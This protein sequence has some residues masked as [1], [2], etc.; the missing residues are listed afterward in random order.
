MA[1]ARAMEDDGDVLVLGQDVGGERRGVPR[2][3]GPPRTVRRTPRARHAAGG[4]AHLRRLGRHGGAGPSSRCAK[5]S[6]RGSS[7]PP[8]TSSRTTRRGL[9]TR[10]RG[11]MTCPPWCCAPPAGGGIHAPEH[12]SES[13]E[14]FLA[15]VPGL[16]CVTP[17]TPRA[18]LRAAA[19]PPSAIRIRW[20]SSSRR[21]CTGSRKGRS[22]TT[23]RGLPLGR[24]LRGARRRR[25]HPR[26]VGRRDVGRAGPPR[27]ASKTRARASSSSTSR[28]SRRSTRTPCSIRCAAPDGSSS[29]TRRRT[30]ED[31]GRR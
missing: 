7:T 9:R 29:H 25:R 11:R 12:H 15:H 19:F 30:R 13:I 10:T 24:G 22:R 26:L 6:S 14:A 16:K 2:H 27:R 31:S 4:A 21:A 5:S 20:C 3:R 23:G 18:R 1:L 17:S 8:S 28:A